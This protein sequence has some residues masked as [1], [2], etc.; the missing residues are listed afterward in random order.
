MVSSSAD[1]S[2]EVESTKEEEPS[3]NV[4]PPKGEG[5]AKKEE[6]KKVTLRDKSIDK[7][8]RG[9]FAQSCVVPGS[10]SGKVRERDRERDRERGRG[11]DGTIM[12]AYRNLNIT[13][14]LHV[15]YVIAFNVIFNCR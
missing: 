8:T 5:E 13:Y 3:E 10:S 9:A 7:D 1:T 12:E 14:N 11:R 4:P 2:T 15:H 6:E